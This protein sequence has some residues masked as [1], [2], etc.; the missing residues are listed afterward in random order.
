[1]QVREV[2]VLGNVRIGY[3]VKPIGMTNNTNQALLPFIERADNMDAFYGP[4]D[5]GFALGVSA[6]CA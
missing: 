1:M 2:P 6:Q 4:F 5:N 3:Q